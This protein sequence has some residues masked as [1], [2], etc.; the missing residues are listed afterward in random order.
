MM[1]PG[2]LPA[3]T[4]A[5]IPRAAAVT[6]ATLSF[7][8]M[9]PSARSVEG[10][11]RTATVV[12]ARGTPR[13]L[14]RGDPVAGTHDHRLWNMGPRVRGDDGGEVSAVRTGGRE[15]NRRCCDRSAEV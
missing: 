10:S 3:L 13:R 15:T 2:G 9:P 11:T 7:N 6:I 12:P 5:T 4:C 14:R 8:R 1:A